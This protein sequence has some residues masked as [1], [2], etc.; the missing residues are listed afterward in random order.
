[1]FRKSILAATALTLFATGASFAETPQGAADRLEAYLDQFPDLG[2]G[3]GVV[4]VTAEDVVLNHVI[5]E[6]RASNGAPMTVDTPQYIASQTKAFLGLV[7]AK[8]DEDG[9]LDLDSALTDHWPDLVFPDGVDPSQWTLRDLLTHQ[10]PVE[11]GLINVL[12]IYVT[13]IASEEYPALIAQLA[14]ARDPGFEYDNLG[15]NIYA[16]ILESATGK[17]WR[18]WLDELVFDP[19]DMQHSSSRTSDFPM[20]DLAFSHIWQGED[21]GWFEIR[22]KTDAQMQS[23]GGIFASTSDMGT[24]LQM[25]LRGEGPSGSG[26]TQTMLT[27]A[28]TSYV[29]THMEDGNNEME[30][31]CSGYSLGWNLCDFEGH[32]IYIHGGS[33]DG[34]RSV[35]AFSPELGIGI[36]AFSNSDNMTGWFV[37]RTVNMFLQYL[38]GDEDAERMQEIRVEH[39]PERVSRYLGYRQQRQAEARAEDRWGGWDWEPDASVL[40]SYEGVYTTGNP[41]LDVVLVMENGQL[42][43]RWGDFVVPLVPAQPD[44]FGGYQTVYQGIDGFEFTRDAAGDVTGLDWGN[45]TYQRVR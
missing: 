1:M 11:A 36:A 43:A 37:S 16:A 28:H 32:L 24:W 25:H 17:S 7:A 3:F 4:V 15:Y 20:N 40:A 30:L 5:G 27:Q 29:E 31:P 33:F 13:E 6:R 10:V 18:V 42:I 34:N 26:L 41:Y 19:L 38:V 23:A 9:I 8:L 2:P 39:Y 45:D 44:L 21:D 35:G 22:P 12:E 14:E